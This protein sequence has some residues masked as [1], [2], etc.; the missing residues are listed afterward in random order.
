MASP[1]IP[2]AAAAE[3]NN[4]LKAQAPRDERVA[5]QAAQA[6]SAGWL[7]SKMYT[8][9]HS[10][11]TQPGKTV[12][13]SS[14]VC[15]VCAF[16]WSQ[17]FLEQRP[18]K[19]YTPQATQAL[20]DRAFVTKYFD[21]GVL[22]ASVYLTP[23]AG[24]AGVPSKAALT[25]LHG[26]IEAVGALNATY[27]DPKTGAS[28]VTN[29]ADICAKAAA[30]RC[31]V[32]S[33]LAL[34]GYTK[35]TWL[36]DP[37]VAATMSP[38]L[39]SPNVR[40][41]GPELRLS[42]VIGSP[43]RD[44]AGK[45]AGTG[46][47]LVKFFYN[48]NPIDLNDGSDPVDP[49]VRAWEMALYDYVRGAFTAGSAHWVGHPFGET[50]RQVAVD[51]AF[52]H[53][54][55]LTNIASCIITLYACW[56]MHRH[57]D[58]L[59]SRWSLGLWCV[60]AVMLSVGASF[61]ILM[62]CGMVFSLTSSAVI[63]VLLGLG[64]DDAFVIVAAID[65]QD[66]DLPI[67]HRIAMGLSSAG[68]SI[69]LTSVTDLVA[70]AVGTSTVVPALSSFCAYASVAVT[71]NLMM[72]CTFFV[73]F[74]TFEERR[75]A[76][77]QTWRKHGCCPCPSAADAAAG[78]ASTPR[79][80]D[81]HRSISQRVIG[82]WLP[83]AI[84][85]GP[86]KV[87]VLASAAAFLAVAGVG[88]SHLKMDFKF[89]WFV[90]KGH[91]VKDVMALRET[92]FS[93]G[94]RVPVGL[95][96]GA[97]DYYTHRAAFKS[98]TT[99]FQANAYVAPSSVSSWQDAFALSQAGQPAIADSAT[100]HAKVKAFVGSASGSAFAK[101]VVFAPGTNNIVATFVP[102]FFAAFAGA[103]QEL[104]AMD[105]VRTI[106]AIAPELKM[107]SYSVIFVFGEGLKVV[108]V[109]VVR[110][111]VLAAGCVFLVCWALLHSLM[112]AGLV[113]LVVTMIDVCLLG[114]THWIGESI[115]M[116]TAINLLLAVG[117]CVDY[118]AHIAHSFMEAVGTRQERAH[119]AL[120]TIGP[121]VFNG[122]MSTLLATIIMVTAKTYVFQSFG[123]M[124]ALIVF[125]G[126]YF[127][128][129][130]LPVLLSIIGPKSIKPTLVAAVVAQAAGGT[131]E[132]QA[133]NPKQT[134]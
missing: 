58:W 121:S 87:L 106:A 128:M 132:L 61:G 71:C 28:G 7:S 16:G 66:R 64:V 12:K 95:Y 103:A 74:A 20:D 130:V 5:A 104:K 116:V 94:G 129:M 8:L 59:R 92:H 133:R 105:S 48:F 49:K 122:G 100:Y 76:K 115:N 68:G 11:A 47:L 13:L 52:T 51:S 42:S 23:K 80:A 36:A 14:L 118:A 113:L 37:D 40:G 6:H 73:A 60:T 63:F 34:W 108:E 90:P 70:F 24:A 33:P 55:P 83:N 134:V 56:V 4:P 93:T 112:A 25:E 62:G 119:L 29:L 43:T 46:A 97:A 126:V 107:V 125:F 102:G 85:S 84:L 22:T 39:F 127:G 57:G 65:R 44:G 89:E 99:A 131:E 41:L 32:D 111:I 69:T 18:E 3:K 124:F 101:N 31:A 77:G 81:P 123:K 17:I 27:T 114:F 78:I 79:D 72:Q 86:G 110:N 50:A 26:M 117:L 120:S 21:E 91:W 9:G 1:V 82:G 109:E 75:I 54:G 67:P 96:T 15:L 53:D 10:V 38:L 35:A 45:L 88:V 98:M 30:G 19:L 2:D